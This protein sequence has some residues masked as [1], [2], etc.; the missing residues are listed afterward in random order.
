[1]RI[2]LLLLLFT[3]LPL[4]SPAAGTKACCGHTQVADGLQN[5]HHQPVHGLAIAVA[6][7]SDDGAV[8]SSSFDLDCG[9]CHA[10]CAAAVFTNSASFADPS[11]IEHFEHHEATHVPPWHARPY[12]PQW[13]TPIRSGFST[14]A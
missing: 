1:M 12:R 13:P 5:K 14:A 6:A 8:F 9:T 3:L 10:N 2:F 4:Q 11:G 7:S